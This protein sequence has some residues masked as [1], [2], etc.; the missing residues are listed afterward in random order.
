MGN[1]YGKRIYRQMEQGIRR[2][3]KLKP[4]QKERLE[5]NKSERTNDL[6]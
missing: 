1:N 4:R 5:E 6:E 2:S 3:R